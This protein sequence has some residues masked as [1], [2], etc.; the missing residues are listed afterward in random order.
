MLEVLKTQVLSKDDKAII[1]SQ[2]SSY[3]NL[4]ALHL[5]ENDVI[6]DQ[7][8]G[9]VPVNKRM[10]MVNRFNDPKDSVRV[11]LLALLLP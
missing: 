5:K 11:R 4:V 1:V 9:K 8:D 3:L 2:W 7:L 10:E 6:F